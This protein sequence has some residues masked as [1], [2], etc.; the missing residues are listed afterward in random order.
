ML[1]FRS[2]RLKRKNVKRYRKFNKK[3]VK[4]HIR[5]LR[6]VWLTWIILTNIWEMWVK[7]SKTPL[8]TGLILAAKR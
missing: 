2:I 6:S 3:T 7:S 8:R 4:C 1:E 5:T